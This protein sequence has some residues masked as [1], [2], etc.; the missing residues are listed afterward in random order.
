LVNET[1]YADDFNDIM[2]N[3]LAPIHAWTPGWIDTRWIKN[4]YR[5]TYKPYTGIWSTEPGQRLEKILT[6]CRNQ[7][8]D[9][10][11]CERTFGVQ[12][13]DSALQIQI[14]R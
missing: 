8:W 14:N 13:I 4:D 3:N 2:S 9:C 6:N 7:C 11:E 12:D 10:H 5:T 1:V